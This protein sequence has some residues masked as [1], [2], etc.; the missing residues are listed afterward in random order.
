M[1]CTTP[2]IWGKTQSPW[3]ASRRRRIRMRFTARIAVIAVVTFLAGCCAIQRL[4]AKHEQLEFPVQLAKKKLNDPLNFTEVNEHVYALYA[5]SDG[6]NGNMGSN[7]VRVLV[8]AWK[9]TKSDYKCRFPGG[10]IVDAEKPYEMAE[11]HAMPFGTYFIN[12]KIPKN[13][14]VGSFVKFTQGNSTWVDAPVIYNIPKKYKIKNYEHKLTICLPYFFGDLYTTELLVEFMELNRILGVDHVVVYINETEAF[15]HLSEAIAFYK[16]SNFLEVIHL[17][18]P[19]R[20]DQIWYHGQLVAVTDCLYRNMGVSR[21]VA[22]QDL[23]EFLI[24]QKPE[25]LPRTAPLLMLMET[26]LV[27]DIASIRVPTQYM[28]WK[29]FGELMTLRNTMRQSSIDSGL[30]KCV[31]RPEMIFEQGIHHT[32]RVIQDHYNA[33]NGD[34]NVIRLYHF[35]MKGGS[36]EDMRIVRDYGDRLTQKY[37]EVMAKLSL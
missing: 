36:Q 37:R 25:L 14:T 27:D 24:P 19:L 34:E 11:N 2:T 5:I 31:L 3:Q 17:P 26:L 1:G 32:S 35:K 21:F 30:T 7:R 16:K 12:C 9:N 20:D 6:R 18:I 29:S 13:E 15:T 8:V 28:H 23:D 4:I 33:T 22:F 10:T